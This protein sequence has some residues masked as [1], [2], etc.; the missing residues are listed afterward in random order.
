MLSLFPLRL[1]SLA[2][3][4]ERGREVRKHGEAGE[5]GDGAGAAPRQVPDLRSGQRDRAV[6]GKDHRFDGGSWHRTLHL[7]IR[8][9]IYTC[10]LG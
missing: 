5:L 4:G 2:I 8:L 10:D 9:Y 1:G 6:V 7:E 3:L